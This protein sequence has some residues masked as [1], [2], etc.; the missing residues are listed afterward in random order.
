VAWVGLG[1]SARPTGATIQTVNVT[2]AAAEIF[3]ELHCNICYLASDRLAPLFEGVPTIRWIIEGI[4]RVYSL[5]CESLLPL[6]PGTTLGSC[7]GANKEAA[8]RRRV[9]AVAV[10]VWAV[11]SPA[12]A[13]TPPI[14]DRV[15]ISD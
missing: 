13:E 3:D 9:Q 6:E 12:T 8:M 1:C 11:F 15:H 5:D 4:D 7:R 2:R 10:C 14:G